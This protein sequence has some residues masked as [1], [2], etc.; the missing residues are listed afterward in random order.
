MSFI[1]GAYASAPADDAGDHLRRVAELPGF[2]GVELP[3]HDDPGRD[4]SSVAALRPEWDVVLTAIAATVLRNQREPGFGLASPDETGRRAAVATA[5]ALADQ[6]RVIDDHAGRA[7]VVAVELHSAPSGSG[8]TAAFARS[9]AELAELGWDDALVTV[10]HC[11]SVAG[12]PPHQKGYLTFDDELAVVRE[13]DSRFAMTVN[14]GRSAI[15][16]RSART[17]VEHV[18]A[19]RDAGRLG[20]VMFSGATDHESVYGV[21]WLDAHL[22]PSTG[23]ETEFADLRSGTEAT[24]LLGPAQIRATLHAAGGTQRF[25]GLKISVRPAELD[26]ATRIEHVRAA[27]EL[28][29]RVTP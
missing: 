19:L 12:P 28:L 11:D 17:P 18:T 27:L 29:G 21:P 1:V 10:E 16:G 25:T 7:A 2:G 22:P 26:A 13:T 4:A 8:T 24:S 14:W 5:R 15:D 6:V 9:L 3:F 20:G 23:A